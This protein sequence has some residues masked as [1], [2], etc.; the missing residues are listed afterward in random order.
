MSQRK[1][2][3]PVQMVSK[4][5][6]FWRQFN[7]H[8]LYFI[9]ELTATKIAVLISIVLI[10]SGVVGSLSRGGVTSLIIGSMIT[11][12]MYGIAR[13]PKYSGFILLPLIGFVFALTGWLNLSSKF[14]AA[15]GKHRLCQFFK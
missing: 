14:G 6:P 11:L 2:S 12:A 13:R 8:L 4:E 9:A 10:A 15:S 3:G 7:F 5:M 1:T